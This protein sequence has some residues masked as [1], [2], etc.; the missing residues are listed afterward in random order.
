MGKKFKERDEDFV[1]LRTAF[2]RG[3]ELIRKAHDELGNRCV[4]G[5]QWNDYT[6]WCEGGNV[7]KHIQLKRAFDNYLM[8]P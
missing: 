6:L 3:Y 5:T 7:C 4:H 8:S 1:K 2:D